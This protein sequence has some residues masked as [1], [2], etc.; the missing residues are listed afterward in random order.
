MLHWGHRGWGVFPSFKMTT[1]SR[2]CR[3]IKCTHISVLVA[4]RPG[5][6]S[7]GQ[8]HGPPLAGKAM[9]YIR[10]SCP[11][12]EVFQLH[13]SSAACL[14]CVI[15]CPTN[16]PT[17]ISS[18]H[19]LDCIRPFCLSRWVGPSPVIRRPY[20]AS[21]WVPAACHGR[22]TTPTFFLKLFHRPTLSNRP[23]MVLKTPWSHCGSNDATMPLS[24]QKRAFSLCI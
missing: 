3:C 14:C 6:P 8:L 2:T 22:Q 21:E 4:A 15:L 16:D 13:L 1:V 5:N 24:A 12:A 17:A 7:T 20:V 9:Q 11:V 10:G 19:S 18:P 23:D